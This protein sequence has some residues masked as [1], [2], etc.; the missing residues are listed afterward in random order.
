MPRAASQG[1]EEERK[2]DLLICSLFDG[3]PLHSPFL[4]LL[5]IR[6]HFTSFP[7][8]RAPRDG[9]AAVGDLKSFRRETI[10]FLNPSRHLCYMSR[11]TRLWGARRGAVFQETIGT[12]SCHRHVTE[13]ASLPH[14]AQGHVMGD[15][16]LSLQALQDCL[17]GD[18]AYQMIIQLCLRATAHSPVQRPVRRE[19]RGKE[20][21]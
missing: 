20:M 5:S 16:S 9:S 12:E 8:C 14:G 19:K 13:S 21:R 18:I 10:L 11:S 1:Q 17:Y 2:R 15:S 6:F 4:F 3:I 7:T